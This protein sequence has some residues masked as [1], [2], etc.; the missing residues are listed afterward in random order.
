MVLPKGWP[1]Q[2][3][4]APPIIVSLRKAL[5]GL[6]Q[7]LWLWH[8]DINTFVLSLGFT[9][10]QA[11]PN[12]C[13]RSDGILILLYV[14]D[15]SMMYARTESAS[16]A[17][18]EV[19]A[20]LP[21]KYK[22]TNLSP[23]RQFLAIE[24]HRDDYGI[25]PG[26]TAFITSILKRFHMQDAH[27]VTTPVDPNVKLDLADD[28]GEKELDTDSAKHYQ[29]IVGSLLY[30]ALAMRPDISYEVAALCRYNSCPFTSHMTAAKRV[31]Q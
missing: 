4:H 11:D 1:H 13:I 5:Y 7:A 28:R 23:A 15:I 9:E 8:N 10:S 17:V 21:E 12:L 29:A 27:G 20:K 18:I 24:I 3:T 31:L 19:T 30:A 14:D 25:S 6:K 22:I 2:D 16:K 26:Q